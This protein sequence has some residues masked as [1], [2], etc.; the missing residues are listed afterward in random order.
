M[1][2][3][4]ANSSNLMLIMLNLHTHASDCKFNIH[5][6]SNCFDHLSPSVVAHEENRGH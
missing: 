4:N 1:F 2:F 6:T 3:V 5:L